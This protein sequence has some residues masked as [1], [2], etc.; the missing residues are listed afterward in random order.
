MTNVH[1]VWPAE[2]ELVSILVL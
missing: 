2:I 1:S